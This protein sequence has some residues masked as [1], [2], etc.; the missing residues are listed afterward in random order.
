M[1][2][3]RVKTPVLVMTGARDKNTPPGQALEFY[4]SV[5]EH[6][7]T[8]VLV[9][10]SEDGHSLRGH[11]AFFDTAARILQWLAQHIGA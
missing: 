3:D 4:S 5:R 11:P 7:G 9:I 2:A 1:F 10:Y 8:A 6:G